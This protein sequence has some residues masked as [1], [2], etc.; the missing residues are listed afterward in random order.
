MG[1]EQMIKFPWQSGTDLPVGGT[2][3][4][5]LVRYA[6][7]GR[8]MHCPSPSSWLCDRKGIKPIEYLDITTGGVLPELVYKE[9]P[10]E[11]SWGT[12]T[13]ELVVSRL[14]RC[15]WRWW[16]WRRLCFAAGSTNGW[17]DPDVLEVAQ[18]V[19]SAV[20]YLTTA[21]YWIY[22]YYHI[23]PLVTTVT[24]CTIAPPLH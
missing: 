5:T 21:V 14:K 4:T 7:L 12:F 18:S 11:S 2:D 3:I 1:N 15:R 13:M 10:R 20:S 23:R 19:R 17:V 16:W 6:F 22:T 8:G 24:A 9:S